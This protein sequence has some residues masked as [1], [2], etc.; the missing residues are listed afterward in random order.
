M[1]KMAARLMVLRVTI[2]R[3]SCMVVVLDTGL[4]HT[5]V[6]AAGYLATKSIRSF[7]V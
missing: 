5:P 7:V 3:G 2:L 1:N 6:N 4:A